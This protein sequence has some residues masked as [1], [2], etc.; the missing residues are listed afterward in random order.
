M[1]VVLINITLKMENK[2]PCCKYI[3]YFEI[4]GDKKSYQ[5]PQYFNS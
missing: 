4:E 5:C 3:N 1:H 2:I